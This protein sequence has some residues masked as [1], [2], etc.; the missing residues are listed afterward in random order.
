M[1]DNLINE[2]LAATGWSKQYLADGV[3]VH[4]S[5]VQHWTRGAVSPRR[6]AYAKLRKLLQAHQADIEDLLSR[7]DAH[8]RI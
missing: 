7:L 4:K 1:T 3:E 5:T 8:L 2:T 6:M